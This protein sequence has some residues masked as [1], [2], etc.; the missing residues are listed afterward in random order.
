MLRAIRTYDL[1]LK[2]LHRLKTR[3]T[4][5]LNAG[6]AAN[7]RTRDHDSDRTMQS[8]TAI[9][10]SLT[11]EPASSP[12]EP[13]GRCEALSPEDLAEVAQVVFPRRLA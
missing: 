2:E 8:A 10:P 6:S 13:N 11:Q 1:R 3:E 4:E 7:N 5:Q 12:I 9:A